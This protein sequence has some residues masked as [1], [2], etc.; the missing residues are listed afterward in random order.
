M[1]LRGLLNCSGYI[2]ISLLEAWS[3]RHNSPHVGEK[4]SIPGGLPS[5][6]Q[7]SRTPRV[8]G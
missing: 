2:A 7:I 8:K 1:T 4:E 3:I 6:L 5:P